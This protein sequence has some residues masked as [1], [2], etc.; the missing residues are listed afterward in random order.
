[1]LQQD[2]AAGIIMRQA[3]ATDAA[4]LRR[5]QHAIYQEGLAFVGDGPMTEG[6][7]A[8]RIRSI[9]QDQSQYVV[10]EE[11]RQRRCLCAW[12]ELHRLNAKKLNHVATLTLAVDQD[13]RKQNL[14]T[15]LLVHAIMWSKRVGVRKIALNVKASN[16]PAIKLYEKYDFVVEGKEKD[17]IKTASGYED[18]WIM[19]KFIN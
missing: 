19:A 3:Y 4:Q 15:A 6:R 18:N 12:L 14:A 2:V 1:M 11:Q 9:Q 10:I 8:Q 17:H 5:L 7:I 13:Y 16:T